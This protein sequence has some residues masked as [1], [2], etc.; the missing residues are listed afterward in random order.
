MESRTGKK[1]LGFGAALHTPKDQDSMF[2]ETT[3]ED[4]MKFG[5]IPEFIGRLSVITALEG[6]DEE[7][8]VRILTEPRNALAKQYARLFAIDGVELEFGAGCPY[9][10]REE[11]TR[12]RHGCSRSTGD[13]GGGPPRHDVRRP[14]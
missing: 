4:L 5:L 2:A 13:H 8:L 1:G 6:L 12:A 10:H 7:T 14:Q 3:P 11:G 9:G